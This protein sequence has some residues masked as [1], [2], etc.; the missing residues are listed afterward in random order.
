MYCTCTVH[1]KYAHFEEELVLHDA[2]H[3]FD[4]QVWQLQLL[5]EMLSQL[6]EVLEVLAD[7]VLGLGL[8]L[9]VLDVHEQPSVVAVEERRNVVWILASL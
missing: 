1:V 4:E 8:V 7:Q 9:A 6:F 5:T 3:G 2:L